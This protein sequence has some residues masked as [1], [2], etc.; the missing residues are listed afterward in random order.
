MHRDEKAG[1]GIL[2]RDGRDARPV[3]REVRRNVDVEEPDGRAAFVDERR[4]LPDRPAVVV[5][6]GSNDQR[7]VARPRSVHASASAPERSAWSV[8]RTTCQDPLRSRTIMR[9]AVPR[10]GR[11]TAER[12][13]HA[14]GRLDHVLQARDLLFEIVRIGRARLGFVVLGLGLQLG[15]LIQA[16]R[17]PG[18]ACVAG[19]H[20][21]EEV[22]VE[23][24]AVSLCQNVLE[25]LDEHRLAILLDREGVDRLAAARGA[26]V[27]VPVHGAK[28]ITSRKGFG[29]GF[30]YCMVASVPGI[31]EGRGRLVQNASV[32]ATELIREAILDGRLEPGSRLKEEELA[33]ELGISRTPV[34]EALLM[35]QAEGLIETTPNRGAV[36]RD[37]RRRRPDRPLPAACAARG[38]RGA[39]GGREGHRGGARACCARA[40]T[41][42]TRIAGDDF[43][44]LV[45]ENLLFHSAIHAAAGERTADGML[46][47]VIQ[48]PL[49]YKAYV[50]YPPD[51]KRIS[52]HYHQQITT[53]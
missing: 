15:V 22:G 12:R 32:A 46:R 17:R 13:L 16:E 52:A 14:P 48:L 43:R 20:L 5:A 6:A 50:W 10:A 53:R 9:P 44:E 8:W 37:A 3:E 39:T 11:G 25:L 47:R 21:G 51:Q 35:L 30:A 19:A 49:V 28:I 42:S 4:A 45:K 40:A 2:V 33:R 26:Y 38:L 34:R 18:K 7:V 41:A 27:R 1:V 24:R 36:V 31:L 29:S 23:T